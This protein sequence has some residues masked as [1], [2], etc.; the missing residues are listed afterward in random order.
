MQP[1]PPPPPSFTIEHKKQKLLERILNKRLEESGLQD[2]ALDKKKKKRGTWLDHPATQ[3]II[4]LFITV[5][6][7]SFLFLNRPPKFSAAP[8]DPNVGG[9][10]DVV[11]KV[12]IYV[13]VTIGLVVFGLLW[14]FRWPLVNMVR[15]AFNYVGSGFDLDFAIK[16]TVRNWDTTFPMSIATL[17][18]ASRVEMNPRM[19]VIGSSRLTNFA[20]QFVVDVFD[21]NPEFRAAFVSDDG[22]SLRTRK[23]VVK[24]KRMSGDR[25]TDGREY[26]VKIEVYQT[27]RTRLLNW[28]ASWFQDANVRP[29][30]WFNSRTDKYV[31]VRITQTVVSHTG[32]DVPRVLSFDT[33]VHYMANAKHDAWMESGVASKKSG[34]YEVSIAEKQRIMQE[35]KDQRTIRGKVRQFLTSPDK[36]QRNF[37]EMNKENIQSWFRIARAASNL[38]PERF[39]ML[40]PTQAQFFLKTAKESG[41]VFV[42]KK[43]EDIVTHLQRQKWRMKQAGVKVLD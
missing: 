30:N 18:G 37:I 20:K 6:V 33:H 22:R 39:L 41:S 35:L 5:G 11:S 25:T 12:P 27:L 16:T 38:S 28:L 26:I 42:S 14:F 32:F 7:V 2:E 15:F 34:K 17:F 24:S 40:F 43:E 1:P 31:H 29:L 36:K 8:V 21:A 10:I 19:R 3:L 4:A 9:I 13:R 23:V